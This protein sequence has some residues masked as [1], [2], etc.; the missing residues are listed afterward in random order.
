MKDKLYKMMNWPEIEA[1][2]YGEEGMPQTILGR[3]NVSSYTLFQTFQPNAKSVVLA[4][5]DDKK[6]DKSKEYTME[7]A[8]EE[9]F[10]AIAIL[11]KAK[12]AYHYVVTDIKG[13]RH[14]VND[15][16]DKNIYENIIG[17]K[18]SDADGFTDGGMYG[19]YRIFGSHVT[20]VG[21]YKGVLFRV[22][23]PN[24]IRVSVVGDF[25]EWN[26]KS[27]P[28]I[29]DEESGVFSLFV[30]GLDGGAEYNYELHVKGGR[31]LVK[32]DPYAKA[33]EDG[34]S[35]VITDK[36]YKWVDTDFY[37]NKAV[38]RD[39]K[40]TPVS[41]YEFDIK[42]IIGRGGHLSDT[43]ADK[44]VEELKE[45]GYT[46]VQCAITGDF[47]Y[48]TRYEVEYSDIQKFVAKLHKAGIGLIAV[49]NPAYFTSGEDGLD[50][51]DG[52]YLYGHMDERK[53]YNPAYNGL[54]YNYDR[55][56]VRAYLLS[57]ARFLVEEFHVDG[58]HIDGL[59]SMLYL[60]YGKYDGEWVAN[61][62]GG[63]ENLEAIDF[64]KALNSMLHKYF[65]HIITTTKEVSAFP[66]VTAPVEEDGLGFD[67]VWNNGFMEDY[68]NFIKSE[69][70][71]GNMHK[72][73]DNMSYAYAENYVLTIS[74]DDVLM[75]NDYDHLRVENGATLYDYIPVSD[76]N[77]PAVSRATL[78]FMWAHPGKKLLSKGQATPAQLAVLNGMYK[79]LSAFYSLDVNPYGFEWIKS[80]D[81]GDG[82][83][84]FVRKDEY[85]NHS[86]F[87][88]CNF[89]W[90]EY[91][92]YKFGM[93][94][95]GKYK[96]IFNSEDKKYGGKGTVNTRFKE[97]KEEF[98]D[99]RANSLT[100]K[101]APM[102][103]CYYSYTPYTEQELLKI[104]QEKVDRFKEKLEK[105]AKEKAKELKGKSSSK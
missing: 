36:K 59:T 31:I 94:Y 76:E 28:M 13:K 54:Y 63:H 74:K 40:K 97:T 16:Y 49:W 41:I 70:G 98:Y 46:Y 45:A 104:A 22:W 95:E 20:T 26:G 7:L 9:G 55:P 25:N 37:G 69:A 38:L 3:H 100:V 19:A 61:I 8:D 85:L 58:L 53:R 93:P 82:V 103:V 90:N 71:K 66:K 79:E 92:N 80:I 42:D 27:H 35:V 17:I 77:K 62:Y 14:I 75:A 43:S 84:A 57:S 23:A 10:Y 65:P 64:I 44:L 52:T 34:R 87:V 68:V 39:Y 78:A 73:T 105:E 51:Y 12:G 29:K 102:S 6:S 2:V 50:Q 72:I 83:V 5:E 96:M 4:L 86:I 56:E 1:I 89:S 91:A 21:G 30:P 67:L 60:D 32:K 18:D 101:L 81:D 99:G 15:P 33:I 47:P 11:G 48:T 24:A 88:V